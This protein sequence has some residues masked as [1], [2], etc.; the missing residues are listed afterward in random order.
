MKRIKS[1]PPKRAVFKVAVGFKQQDRISLVLTSP[2]PATMSLPDIEIV[3]GGRI[4]L[5]ELDK[6]GNTP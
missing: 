4:V 2:D 1:Q 6:A 5:E 3:V